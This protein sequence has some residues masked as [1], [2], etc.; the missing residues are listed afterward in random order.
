MR[1]AI[2]TLAERPDLASLVAQWRV[3]AFLQGVMT[4]AQYMDHLLAP[5]RGPEASFIALAD[6][7]PVGTAGVA[8]DDLESRPDLTPWLVGVVVQPGHRGQG[9][10]TALVREAE[11][12]ARAA[13][14]PCL[15]LYTSYAEG[16]YARLGWQR[17]GVER[18]PDA[19]WGRDVVLMQR[20]LTV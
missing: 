9:H 17:T 7:T 15:W 18:D 5:A 8:H 6:G 4:A 1:R 20:S 12:F 3:E 2:V 13:G 10:A 11:S 19:T 14:V 16:F